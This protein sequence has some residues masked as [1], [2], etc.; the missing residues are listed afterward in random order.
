ML[1]KLFNISTCSFNENKN[2]I[3]LFKCLPLKKE[4]DFCCVYLF[5]ISRF[6]DSSQFQNLKKK[7]K[8][9]LSLLIIFLI[10]EKEDCILY[11]GWLEDC[12]SYNQLKKIET[13]LFLI[14]SHFNHPI[15]LQSKQSIY[16]FVEKITSNIW[17]N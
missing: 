17:V 11:F 4:D 7:L 2:K 15:Q 1:K 10:N 16:L 13:N 9:I 12:K 5:I 6:F 3:H 8:I 14:L